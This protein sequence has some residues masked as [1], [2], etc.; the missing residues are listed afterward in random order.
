MPVCAGIYGN[1]FDHLESYKVDLWYGLKGINPNTGMPYP[2][3]LQ[4]AADKAYDK[5]DKYYPTSES[6]VYVAS[7]S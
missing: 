4:Q 6:L 7:T 2:K 5:L 1:L 3:W